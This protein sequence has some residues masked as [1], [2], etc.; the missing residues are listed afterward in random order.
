MLSRLPTSVKR[1][2]PVDNMIYSLQIDTFPATST[3]IRTETLKDKTL[4]NVLSHL[5]IRKWPDKIGSHIKPCYNKRNE[6]TIGDLELL[7]Q[8]N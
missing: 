3:E 4:F 6:L 5:Q 1:E 7:Y 8:N 2:L